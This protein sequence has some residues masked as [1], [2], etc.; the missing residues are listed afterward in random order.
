MKI[1]SRGLSIAAAF[2]S[3][4][5]GLCLGA[6]A[7]ADEYNLPSLITPPPGTTADWIVSVS[8]MG[9]VAPSFPGAKTYSFFG[10]PG[11]SIRRADQPER[12]SA[13]DDSL[14]LTV[15]HN[16][17]IAV[18][19]AGRW[20]SDRSIK[21][22]PELFGLNDVSA[23]IEVGGFVELTP[24]SWGRIRAEVR[25]AVSGYDGWVAMLGGDVWQKWGPLTLSIGPRLDFGN[26]Q[27][28]S[29]FFSVDPW[30]AALNQWAGGRLTAYNATAGLVDAGFTVA[31]R[32]DLSPAWRISAYGTYQALTGSVANSPVTTQAGS[33]NQFAAG[34][35]IR[36]SFLT[37]D[38][39][40]IPKF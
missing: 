31:A 10:L 37:K 29:A 22:Y 38:L 18:G 28:A 20:V 21:N 32:Y 8:A 5:A 6:A 13:P 33:S 30:Q 19:P 1:S 2:L 11:I 9:G 39:Y 27:Y 24:V 17:W 36:Y 3:G 40:W 25:K 35:E 7:R 4:A 15:L 14:S 12:F 26:D 34:V 16:D 23:S